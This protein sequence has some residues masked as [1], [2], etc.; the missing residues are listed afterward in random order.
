MLLRVLYVL[1]YKFR[2]FSDDVSHHLSVVGFRFNITIPTSPPTPLSASLSQPHSLTASLSQPHSLSL[3]LSVS[4]SSSYPHR[5]FLSLTLS[6]SHSQVGED[7]R[8]GI[9]SSNGKN[10]DL[11]LTYATTTVTLLS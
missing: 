11:N 2:T 1:L 4:L 3:T 10:R 8:Q 7:A 5:H 6:V 9:F